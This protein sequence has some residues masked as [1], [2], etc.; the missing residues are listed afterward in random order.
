LITKQE[1]AVWKV[2]PV[3]KAFFQAANIRIEDAKDILA[4][5]AGLDSISDNFYRGFIQAYIEMFDFRIED[6]DTA[7]ED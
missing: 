5:S 4:Q 1:W 6:M 3:T 2:N 7:D